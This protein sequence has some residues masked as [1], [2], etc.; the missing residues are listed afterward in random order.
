MKIKIPL[1]ELDNPKVPQDMAVSE[2]QKWLDYKRTKITIEVGDVEEEGE[3]TKATVEIIEAI[4]T[5]DL[6]INEDMTMI[7]N[8]S[9]P[10]KSENGSNVLEKLTIKPRMTA[11]DVKNATKGIKRDEPFSIFIGYISVLSGELKGLIKKIDSVDFSLLQKIV[12]Y[13]L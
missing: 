11:E 12:G 3:D 1:I 9:F 4:M 5:G 6:V 10:V 2:F 8:L 7:Y 13:F